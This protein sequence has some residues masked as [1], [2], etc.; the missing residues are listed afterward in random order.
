M[1][2]KIASG[3]QCSAKGPLAWWTRNPAL[4]DEWADCLDTAPDAG[5]AF[6]ARAIA[7]IL[8]HE[9][10]P[11]ASYRQPVNRAFEEVERAESEAEVH[12]YAQMEAGPSPALAQSL[13]DFRA[14]V[15][16]EIADPKVGRGY[17]PTEA[18]YYRP[19]EAQAL[20]SLG[21]IA[22]ATALIATTPLDCYDC[23]RTRGIVAQAQGNAPE[24][25]RWFAEAARQGPRLPSAFAD[26]GKL[27]LQARH[28]A[29]AEVK[30]RYAAKLAPSWADPLKFWGDALAAEGKR[31]EAIAKYDAALKL[32]PKWQ[33]LQQARARL[34][35][36]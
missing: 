11:A 27:L 35:T 36:T 2:R 4:A 15:A 14:A 8:R 13:Q 10:Q 30:L 18:T 32:A 29:S 7:Q 9:W 25:Q 26:W 31:D 12:L 20:A 1:S 16:A 33:A 19:L 24:A 5:S 23:V 6:A 22:E 21:R 34:R 3:G 17:Q 28:Y